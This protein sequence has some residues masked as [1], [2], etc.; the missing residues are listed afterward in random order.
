MIRLRKV[1]WAMNSQGD[2]GLGGQ[3]GQGAVSV[4]LELFSSKVAAQVMED[5]FEMVASAEEADLFGIHLKDASVYQA[6][7]GRC[8]RP[9][10]TKPYGWRE[11]RW[12]VKFRELKGCLANIGFEVE[13]RFTLSSFVLTGTLINST[14]TWKTGAVIKIY[15][16][17]IIDEHE[18]PWICT[19]NHASRNRTGC[20]AT[21]SDYSQQ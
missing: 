9:S 10:C 21:D 4:D 17:S 18:I 11:S 1:W 15:L 14:N 6:L 19:I 12:R 16:I 13:L 3:V 8:L 20:S 2:K 5:V 7:P